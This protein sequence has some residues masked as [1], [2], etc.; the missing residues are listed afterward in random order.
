MLFI[1]RDGRFDTDSPPKI[2]EVLA[3]FGTCIAF[4]NS[5]NLSSSYIFM[6]GL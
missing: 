2:E 1:I 6:V 3:S 5:V 4:A